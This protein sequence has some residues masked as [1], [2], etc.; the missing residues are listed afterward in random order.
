MKKSSRPARSLNGSEMATSGYY[1]TA[2]SVWA[3]SC[4]ITSFQACGMWRSVKTSGLS[5]VANLSWSNDAVLAQAAREVAYE[6]ANT[7]SNPAP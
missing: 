2:A 4:P 6:R 1:F 7:P 3:V 5:D